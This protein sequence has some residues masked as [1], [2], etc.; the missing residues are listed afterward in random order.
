VLHVENTTTIEV[1]ELLVN[2]REPQAPLNND[3]L[4]VVGGSHVFDGSPLIDE[5]AKRNEFVCGMQRQAPGILSEAYRDGAIL[6]GHEA[7]HG[8]V[9][10]HTILLYKKTD[11]TIAPTT[12]DDPHCP[13]LR[14]AT[15]RHFRVTGEV[16][17]NPLNGNEVRELLNI[18]FG[19]ILPNVMRGEKELVIGHDFNEVC[20]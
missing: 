4:H 6:R 13:L 17:E 7:G 20:V 14:L 5:V 3:R 19:L 10:G 12:G 9:L 8:E 1:E 16:L 2:V 15:P 18:E 11:S